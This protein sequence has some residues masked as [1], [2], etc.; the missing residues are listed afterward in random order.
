MNSFITVK[1]LRLSTG[2]IQFF[3]FFILSL[4]GVR[5]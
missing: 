1:V 3:F 2:C 5:E 4:S